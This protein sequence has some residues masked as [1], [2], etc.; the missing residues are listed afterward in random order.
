MTQT[1]A[2]IIGDIHGCSK[3]LQLMLRNIVNHVHSNVSGRCELIFVGD[4]ID[5]GPDSKGVL[6]TVKN[7][8]EWVPEPFDNVVALAGNHEDMVRDTSLHGIWMT[9]GGIQC[10][11]SFGH[12]FKSRKDLKEI[13]GEEMLTWIERLPNYYVVGDVAVAHAGIDFE[14]LKCSEHD[15]EILL[16]SRTLRLTPHEIYKYT[17]HGHTPMKDVLINEHVAYIDTGCVFSQSYSE[18]RPKLSALFIP[19]VNAPV[20]SEMQIIQVENCDA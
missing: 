1:S 17:V 16:W 19:D 7:L 10:L 6:E 5:R 9:N 18:N 4:Y 13:M 14:D 12:D 3:T 2:Y 15:T 11:K 8:V 20:H